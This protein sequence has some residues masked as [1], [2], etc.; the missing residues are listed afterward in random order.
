M[1]TTPDIKTGTRMTLAEFLDLPRQ[2]QRCE[3]I[4][5]VVYMAAFPIPD[6]QFLATVL[7]THLVLQIMETGL[8]IVYQVAGVVVSDSSAL[9]PDIVAVR[10]ERVGI[11]GP[12]VIDGGPPDIVV[13]V[14]SSNR[15][16]DLVRKRELYESAGVPE[17]WIID[18]DANTL[19]VLELAEDG[20]YSERTV[21]TSADTLTTP[22]FPEFSLP[23][24][25]LFEHPAR[26]RAHD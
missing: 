11:I 15:H 18:G 22:L 14:L 1:T 9:G 4:D 16:A 13:E 25:R 7:S 24:A 2:E 8:G 6:H 19:T 3:L 26:V 17:Y 21:L 12:T 23:L 10:S 20:T 5:G